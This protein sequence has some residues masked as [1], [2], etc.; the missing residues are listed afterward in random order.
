[1]DKSYLWKRHNIYWVRVRVPDK[2]RS[3]I[4]KSE[5][6]RNLYTSDLSKAN[7]IK[8]SVIAEFKQE[9]Q[10]NT[11]TMDGL[12]AVAH[13][14]GINGAYKYVKTI[15]LPIG[16]PNK[17]NPEDSNGTMLSDYHQLGDSFAPMDE[18]QP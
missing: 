10:G 16:D 2:V 15:D 9:I 8:H 11:V 12:V 6:S 1:M 13:L 5:L 17:Y 7:N 14:G 18:F 3:I 4:R